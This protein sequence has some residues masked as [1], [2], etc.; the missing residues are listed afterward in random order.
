MS[1]Q[2]LEWETPPLSN[3]T[4]HETRTDRDTEVLKN[5]VAKDAQLGNVRAGIWSA[6]FTGAFNHYTVITFQRASV[7]QNVFGAS[8]H[9][10]IYHPFSSHAVVAWEYAKTN[11]Y[12][13]LK[14]FLCS[15]NSRNSQITILLY[16]NISPV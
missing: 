13:A 8:L 11:K 15:D 1:I 4:T 2:I 12:L 7:Y 14:E 6:S 5:N 10:G 3:L 16:G 9:R